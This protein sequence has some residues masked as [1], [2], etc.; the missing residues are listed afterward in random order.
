MPRMASL[1]SDIPECENSELITLYFSK[2]SPIPTIPSN[3]LAEVADVARTAAFSS[4]QLTRLLIH[5]VCYVKAPQECVQ[6]LQLS[7]VTLEVLETAFALIV[8]CIHSKPIGVKRKI[9][10]RL[11]NLPELMPPSSA[12]SMVTGSLRCIDGLVTKMWPR[13]E[14]VLEALPLRCSKCNYRPSCGVSDGSCGNCGARK[15]RGDR[16]QQFT[17]GTCWRFQLRPLSGTGSNTDMIV[18]V[19]GEVQLHEAGCNFK[20]GSCTG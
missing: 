4:E 5:G 3:W 9:R 11:Y 18:E 8:H 14:V 15:R 17:D 1:L 2:A 13:P 7:T 10:V 19:R 6:A 16:S 20:L 12:E